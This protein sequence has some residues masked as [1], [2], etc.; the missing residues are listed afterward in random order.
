MTTSKTSNGQQH[1]NG[2]TSTQPLSETEVTRVAMRIAAA[3]F[4][5]IRTSD[6]GKTVDDAKVL[7]NYL[8]ICPYVP[9]DSPALAAALAVLDTNDFVTPN[10]QTNGNGATDKVPR[11][12]NVATLDHNN[13]EEEEVEEEESIVD[14]TKPG[15]L[16]MILSI[17]GRIVRICLVDTPLALF[18][19]IYLSVLWTDY[20]QTNYLSRQ[21]ESLRWN[22]E[23][24]FRE[25][26]YYNR[27]CDA[28]DMSASKPADLFLSPNATTED[29]YQHQL[30]HGMTVFPSVL[31][32]QSATELRDFISA[33]N[34]NLSVEESIFV[35]EN[36]NRYSFG[37][38]TEEP[39]V[40][41][42]VKEIANHPRLGPA[43]ERILGADPALIEMT[44]ITS[45]YGAVD[46]YWHDDVVPQGSALKF[47]RAFGP[48]YSFFMQLQNTTTAMGATGVCPGTHMCPDGNMDVFC[49]RDGFQLVNADGYWR[50][51]DVMLMN[52]NTWHRGAAHTD[53]NAQDR[54][55]FILTFVPKPRKRAETRQM[56]QGITFSLRWDMWGHTLLDLA[57]S[58]AVMV[59][60]YAVLRALGVH[61]VKGYTWGLDYV[62]SSSM[63]I[64]NEDNGFRRDELEEFVDRGGIKWLPT[65]LHPELEDDDSYYE[66]YVKALHNMK[67]FGD[68]WT[69]KIMIG[70]T[71]IQLLLFCGGWSIRL[72][73]PSR[74][75]H[76][77]P[78]PFRTLR[79]ATVRLVVTYGLLYVA[80]RAAIA[81]VDNTYWAKDL[82]AGRKYQSPFSS[83]EESA[84]QGP[85]TIP[86][87][88]DV[89]IETRYGSDY[90]K[91]Y[92]DFISNHPGNREWLEWVRQG[93]GLYNDYA[94]LPPVF[95]T[96]IFK[97]IVG[98]MED[99]GGRMLY[100]G[101]FSHWLWMDQR[102]TLLQTS[103]ET[104]TRSNHVLHEVL[105][106]LRYLLSECK[107]G[108]LRTFVMT[109][110]DIL[111]YLE[112]WKNKL[113]KANG[114]DLTVANEGTY[115][116]GDNRRPTKPSNV[117]NRPSLV[118]PKSK[119]AFTYTTLISSSRTDVLP[120]FKPQEPY[121]GAW[122]KQ[123]DIVE[124]K[125]RENNGRQYWYL[126]TILLASSSGDYTVQFHD[127]ERGVE[128]LH[129]MRWYRPVRVGDMVEVEH[130]GD[131]VRAEVLRDHGNDHYDV[132]LKR[133][134]RKL[135]NVY[136]GFF[137]RSF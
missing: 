121:D 27:I 102:D 5:Q 40:A 33:R 68:E 42:A 49:Q 11:S 108:H 98:A 135:L 7:R 72:L 81:H 19:L 114:L 46:Q 29:A 111:P 63:R 126:S 61:I 50:A 41:K 85:T 59:Q 128:A 80:Y 70:Y 91:I 20:V 28:S 13:N 8:K 56:S 119:A 9:K 100:Q 45:S 2:S 21:V 71:V 4:S 39:T 60:P 112:F 47:G 136:K 51:G 14:N 55:M 107:Y 75:Q 67:A 10:N 17:L 131:Y 3:S 88:D 58:N 124:T 117:W 16:S 130:E 104:I 36:T 109:E 95:R 53:P 110:V 86:T 32:D 34:Y 93:S 133:D 74:P 66:Y 26:T 24:R 89:L 65:F 115:W 116:F 106:Q 82:K 103:I 76:S 62:S 105:I 15:V 96:A 129:R 12:V 69:V 79:N 90:L 37:L 84:Y 77:K 78:R 73:F 31:S 38:G 52:M 87:R 125:Y 97:Q 18:F 83:M 43:I 118:P 137:R 101:Q 54:V 22:D 57:N 6:D 64:S 123:G 132:F 99:N 1:S 25:T 92:N 122:M 35:I 120:G 48:S 134:A 113:L 44:A 94:G 30:K 127:G 23:R